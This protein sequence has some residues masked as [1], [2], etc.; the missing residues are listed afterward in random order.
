MDDNLDFTLDS[1]GPPQLTSPMQGIRFVAPDEGVLYHGRLS[2]MQ[3]YLDAGI[4]PP[5]FSIAG[6]RAMLY[7]APDHVRAGIVTCGGLCPGLNDVIRATDVKSLF[8]LRRANN[9]RLSLW[10]SR[11]QPRLRL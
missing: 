2:Q 10:L 9:L 5:A 7:F 3:P 4:A 1:L 8:P 6:P 11:A